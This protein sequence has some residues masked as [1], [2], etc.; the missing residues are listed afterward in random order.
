MESAQCYLGLGLI[1]GIIIA[2]MFG[3]GE[4]H[5]RAAMKLIQDYPKDLAKAREAQK[6]AADNR[7]KGQ[8][9]LPLAFFFMLVSLLVL[10]LAV[11]ILKTLGS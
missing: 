4:H 8:D 1:L 3:I 2:G 11:Y 10:V 7:R 6:K 5:R 9:D